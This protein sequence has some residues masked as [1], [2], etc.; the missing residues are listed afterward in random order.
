MSWLKE[1]REFAVKGNVAARVGEIAFAASRSAS[2]R[3]PSRWRSFSVKRCARFSPYTPLFSF[4]SVI[5][6]T[7]WT[8]STETTAC[9]SFR[10]GPVTRLE[11][12]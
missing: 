9:Q 2:I 1:F 4:I 12:P 8:L 10:F 6:F 7:L 5:G 11:K 3:R